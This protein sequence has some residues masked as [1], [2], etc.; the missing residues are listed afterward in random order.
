MENSTAEPDIAAPGAIKTSFAIKVI[1]VGGAG[2]NALAHMAGESLE[3][4]AYAALNT[5]APVLARSPVPTRII[6]GARSTRGLGAGG[7]PER[8]RAAAEEDRAQI[9]AIC[10]GADI[11]FVVAGLGGGTGTGAAPVVARTAHEMGAL[12]LAIV[13]LPFDCEGNR[14]QS[15]ALDG[16]EQLQAEADGVICL[17]NQKLFKFIDEKTTLVNA[18]AVANNFVAAGIRGIWR[19]LFRPGFINIDFSDL[20]TLTKGKHSDNPL[21]TVEARGEHRTQE[22]IDKLFAHPLIDGGQV[23]AEAT[24]VLITIAGGPDLTMTEVNRISE[25][26]QRQAEHAQIFLGAAI[27]DELDD[28][29]TVT[30]VASCNARSRISA[31][32]RDGSERAERH[33]SRETE[34]RSPVSQSR[35]DP[36]SQLTESGDISRPASRFVPP[37]PELTPDRTEQILVKQNGNPSRQR[38]VVSRMRQG[39]L[40]LEIVS[41]GR[42]EKSE[43]TIHRGEDLDVPTYI[44]RNIALN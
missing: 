27:E 4:V 6:L 3:G 29:I 13:F 9:R 16:L 21:A 17:P 14:R 39:Q 1:G 15:V 28:R 2:C 44:R 26:I 22:V 20:C 42:F 38:R 43:P 30:V 32:G 24:G 41:R 8:G 36:D 19:L 35:V 23:L 10:E 25:Q 5:D 34:P 7:D 18:F 11:V 31:A 37:P 33:R 40:Q 12:V